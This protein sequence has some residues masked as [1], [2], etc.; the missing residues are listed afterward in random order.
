MFDFLA[1][2]FSD[3]FSRFG[4]STTLT[5]DVL[6]K[7]LANVQDVLID[8]DVPLTVARA[9]IDD[10]RTHLTG[11]KIHSSL[12]SE[13]H[14]MKVVHE[15]LCNFLSGN[16]KQEFTFLFP[17]IV[18]VMGLQGSGKTT[19]IAKLA[20]FIMR[21]AHQR[22]KKRT[23]LL[24]SVDY[25][26]PAAIDQLQILSLQAGVDFYRA[27]ATDPVQAAIEIA[28]YGKKHG[29]DLV[30]LDTAGRLHIDETMLQE[31][32]TIDATLTPRYKLLVLDA[33]TGQESLRVAQ[34]FE[35]AIG[36]GAAILS[37]MDSEARG[38]AAF[39]F[40][41]ALKKPIVF[42]G[43][44]EKIADLEQFKPERVA[45]RMLGMGDLMTLIEKANQKIE[46]F[47]RTKQ[48]EMLSKGRFTLIDFAKQLEM[49]Q[50]MGSLSQLMKYIPGAAGAKIS[51]EQLEQGERE[52]KSF[53][54]IIGSMTK[55]ERLVPTL[56]DMSR[57]KRIA[58]GAGVSVTD[59][60]GLL[61]KFH[62]AQKLMKQFGKF[63]RFS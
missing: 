12:N 53:R 61:T 59:V 54:A 63:G 39:S 29:Y 41:Y 1:N 50:S 20:H 14:I 15:R 38:G 31:L 16:E 24:A 18:M 2:K 26:R 49:V 35:S 11:V 13:E 23:I 3:L 7:L 58:S 45:G 55:K 60:N 34:S 42:V 47:E 10:V 48:M 52:M 21:T 22:G 9:F 30:F 46:Q 17:S 5:P 51:S 44:G 8:A 56:L 37:K 25:Y 62:D 40:R 43:C 28:A 32:K 19:T 6:D 33:M 27:Q 36:F 4:R 57:K